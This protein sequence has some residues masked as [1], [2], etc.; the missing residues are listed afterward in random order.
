ME[1]AS[2]ALIIAGAILVSILIISIGVV[3]VNLINP[4]TDE[5]GEMGT[6]TSVQ[7]FNSKFTNFEGEGKK[8]AEVKSL[9]SLVNSTKGTRNITLTWETGLSAV[10]VK[11]NGSYT[12][13]FKYDGEGY[14]S[15][16]RIYT[17]G[18]TAPNWRT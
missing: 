3:I 9:V 6:S 11:A 1:N 5:V 16:I 18:Q 14:V 17:T 7:I 2:K 4:V 13:E 10:K 15:E 8:G 12:M